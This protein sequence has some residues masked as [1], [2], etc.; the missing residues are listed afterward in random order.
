M[1]KFNVGVTYCMAMV[2]M[3]RRTSHCL[4]FVFLRQKMAQRR[5]GSK[6]NPSDAQVK[7]KGVGFRER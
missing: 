2:S 1:G 6:F 4:T 5:C 7:Q 3:P